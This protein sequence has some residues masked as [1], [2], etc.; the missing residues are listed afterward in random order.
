MSQISSECAQSSA[1]QEPDASHRPDVGNTEHENITLLMENLMLD[2]D[3]MF[4]TLNMK[5]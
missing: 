5:I 4:K 1:H 2:I 3:L